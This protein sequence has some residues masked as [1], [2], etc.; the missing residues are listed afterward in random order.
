V[1][2]SKWYRKGGELTEESDEAT[3]DVGFCPPGGSE[4][5]TIVSDLGPIECYETHSESMLV[6]R[7]AGVKNVVYE[8]E[9]KGS[10]P[11]QLINDDIIGYDPADPVEITQ[12]LE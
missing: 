12:G 2:V 1:S 11:E 5:T 10:L 7:R 8:R 6:S 4:W 3:D 9:K